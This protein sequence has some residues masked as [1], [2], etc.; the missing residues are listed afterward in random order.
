M[1]AGEHFGETADGETVRRY[2]I[3]GGGLAASIL[4]YGALVQDLRIEGHGPPLVL[5]FG[6]LEDYLAH[7]PYFGATPGRFSNRIAHGRFTIDGQTFQLD[8]NQDGEHHLHGGKRGIGKRVWQVVDLAPDRLCLAIECADSEMGYPGNCR[9]ETEYT[10]KPGGI[11]SIV[12][13]ATTDRACPINITHHSYFNL[14]GRE[15][16]LDHELMLAADGYLPTGQGQIPTGE[17]APVAGTEFDFREMRPVRHLV[18]GMQADYDHNYCLADKRERMRSVALLRSLHSG[19]T[20]EV[21]TGEP[22]IQFYCGFK[23]NVPVTGLDGRH[24]G[25]YAG[26]CLEAQNWPDAPNRPDFPNAVVLPG[27]ILVQET[28]YVFARS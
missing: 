24:Y 12:H 28:D 5:G 19:V 21:R 7:S 1:E 13:R 15:T 23:L 18:G 25:P 11:L 22:G 6:R 27:E 2:R 8:R 26:L 9:I 4:D 16:I 20:M 17:I 10:L 3:E 14:D